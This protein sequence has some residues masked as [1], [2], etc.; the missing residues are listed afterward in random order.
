MRIFGLLVAAAL[1]AFTM[2][3]SGC[4]ANTGGQLGHA[5]FSYEECLFGCTIAG[6]SMAAGG[7]LATIKAQLASGYTFSQ[8][9]SSNPSAAQFTI[10]SSDLGGGY[11]IGVQSGSPG[12]TELQLLDP[13][14][15]LVDQVT[16]TVAAVAKLGVTQGWSGAGPLVLENTTEA[17][18]VVTQ[19]QNG[20][21][22]IGTGSVA[23]DV[24]GVLHKVS[25]G[26]GD[27][28]GF[29]GSPGSGGVVAHTS[30]SSANLAV[31]V[32]P[33]TALGSLTNT[34][35]PNT[36]SGNITYGNVDVVANSASGA[37]YGGSC[38]WTTSDPSV[39]VSSQTSATLESAPKSSTSFV[40][41]LPGTYTATCTVGAVS[42][43]VSLHR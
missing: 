36:V 9:K 23:F 12:S 34:V 39:T 41:G 11:N 40:L 3:G 20:N 8:V 24:S 43:S 37:V 26:G 13:N 7:A 14:N 19:D 32:V 33:L 35:K 4:I 22:L 6:N 2:I 27:S 10:G 5:Q 21:T 28:Q 31:T 38:Q 16:V 30:T 15:K 1:A 25:A 42:T 29:A 17:F 18:H